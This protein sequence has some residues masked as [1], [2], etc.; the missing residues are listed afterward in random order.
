ML[1]SERPAV[2]AAIVTLRGDLDVLGAASAAAVLNRLTDT[3]ARL[4]LD[5]AGRAVLIAAASASS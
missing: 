3:P 2:A 5:L 4:I 1:T